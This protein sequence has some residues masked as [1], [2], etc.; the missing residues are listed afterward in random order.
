LF[1]RTSD[2]PIELRRAQIPDLASPALSVP[3]DLRR[4]ALPYHE[5]DPV[6]LSVNSL[7][8]DQQSGGTRIRA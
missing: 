4:I 6:P 2:V 1:E 8:K 7:A 5:S 3:H